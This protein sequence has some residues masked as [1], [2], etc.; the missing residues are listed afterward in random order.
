MMI[1]LRGLEC[2]GYSRSPDYIQCGTGLDR[3]T[4]ITPLEF[5][6]DTNCLVGIEIPDLDEGGVSDCIE[7]G[8]RRM[9]CGHGDSILTC[10]M[11]DTLHKGINLLIRGI[12]AHR[13]TDCPFAMIAAR[14]RVRRNASRSSHRF[15]DSR[16]VPCKFIGI[17]AGNIEGHHPGSIRAVDVHPWGS[18]PGHHTS[19]TRAAFM[20]MDG[21]AHQVN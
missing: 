11:P 18:S 4:W 6:K 3:T 16:Q 7:K 8:V 2:T 14:R 10:Q 1:L 19:G 17:M 9:H 12:T 20:R 15:S 5:R 13:C 21:S